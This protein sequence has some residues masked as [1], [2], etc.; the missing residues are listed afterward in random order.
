MRVR[1]DPARRKGN[2]KARIHEQTGRLGTA[3][4]TAGRSTSAGMTMDELT[5][6]W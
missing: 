3:S 2:R 6:P 5:L 4:M 1:T